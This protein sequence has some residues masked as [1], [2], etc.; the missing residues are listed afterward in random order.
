MIELKAIG[1]NLVFFSDLNAIPDKIDQWLQRRDESFKTK[2]QLYDFIRSGRT[3]NS[4]VSI[5]DQY[6]NL[7]SASVGLALIA[8]KYGEFHYT[9]HNDCDL[10]LARFAKEN[11][12]FAVVTNDSD[13]L[14]FDGIFKFWKA[15]EFGFNKCQRNQIIATEYDRNGIADAFD[16][17]PNQRA[18]FATLMGNGIIDSDTL[19]AFQKTLGHPRYRFQNVAKYVI[20][21]QGT[22]PR[23]S[24]EFKVIARNVFRDDSEKW[25]E[26]L[27]KGVAAYNLNYPKI[28]LN[29]EMGNRLIG[30]P[31]YWDY[32]SFTRGG[33]GF[34]L[35]FYDMRGMIG[36]SSLPLVQLDWVKR[37]TGVVR[38]HKN[39]KSYTFVTLIKTAFNENYRAS[40]EKPIYPDCKWFF[41]YWQLPN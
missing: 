26:L 36:T 16:I 3:F 10:E 34:T 8:Q 32:L 37:K 41:F 20:R 1:A 17:E 24:Q 9:I 35:S 19:Y 30:T 11:N 39:E 40:H 33:Q 6:Q 14:I 21:I 38:Q 12:A 23:L 13:F 25:V 31:Y 27:K 5:V 4:I 2:I 7:S 15:T 29:D 28:Q 18:L 22:K